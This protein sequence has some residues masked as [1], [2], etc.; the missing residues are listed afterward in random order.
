MKKLM[1]VLLVLCITP[2]AFA[3]NHSSE[4][5]AAEPLSIQ[6]NLCKLK[7]GKNQRDLDKL[8]NIY[9]DWAQ[10]NNVDTFFARQ[11]PLVTHADAAN[12]LGYEFL[13]L[14]AGPFARQ[15]RA[16]DLLMT[17]PDGEKLA[18]TWNEVVDCNVKFGTGLVM[19]S[20]PEMETDNERIVS[21]NW[22]SVNEGVTIE[23]LMAAH[24]QAA[25]SITDDAPMIGWATLVP[26]VGGANIPGDFAHLVAYPDMESFMR[27]RE[28]NAKIGWKNM[29]DYSALASCSG[30]EVNV[31][32][33]L[34][35]QSVDG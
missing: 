16:W 15:G 28:Y 12:P 33:V 20:K 4:P 31:E 18:A 3:D 14:S 22:C 24:A 13:E 5:E 27:M 30:E 35:R 25:A 23:Q 1:H 26:T 21:W 6:V 8:F 7:Q 32:A 29:R 10:E 17:T 9:L 2:T 34:H 11:Y 19:F